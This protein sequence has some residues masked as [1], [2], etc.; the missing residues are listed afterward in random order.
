MSWDLPS[1]LPGGTVTSA[2]LKLYVRYLSLPQ[3]FVN[4]T[5]LTIYQVSQA[6]TEMGVTWETTDGSTFWSQPGN[7]GDL[8][9]PSVGPVFFSHS[10]YADE[11][12]TEA[13]TIN[14]DITSLVQNWASGAPNYGFMVVAGNDSFNTFFTRDAL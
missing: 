12:P 5:P 7:Q 6:W 3:Q 14:V 1:D 10:P 4:D 8:S 2:G 9:G 13:D 11:I